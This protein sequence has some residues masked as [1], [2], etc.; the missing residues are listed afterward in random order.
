[1][2]PNNVEIVGSKCFSHCQSLSS[3]TFESNSHLTR[4]ESEAFHRLSLQSIS[5]PSTILFI[6]SDAVHI[7][8]Q[9]TLIDG[10]SCPEFDRW[11]QLRRSSIAVDFQRIRKVGFDLPY[12]RNYLVNLSGFEETSILNKSDEVPNQHYH[13]IEDE[14]LVVVKSIPAL[15]S[16][17]NSEIEH[18]IEKLINL[19]HPCIAH[20]IGFVLRIESG[21]LHELK[22]V[23]LYLEGSS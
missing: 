17:D 7:G 11:L 12:L 18:E 19:R 3:I 2:I 9:L 23:R 20:P 4:I 10:D 8:L 6:A 21:I 22:L 14:F 15:K 16:V 1:M 13:R 5:I